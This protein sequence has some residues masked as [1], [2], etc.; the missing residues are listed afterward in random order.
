MM[1]AVEEFAISGE[2]RV[3]PHELFRG[4]PPHFAHLGWVGLHVACFGFGGPPVQEEA[5]V[6]AL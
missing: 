4:D 1:Y 2:G 3:Q 6:V 5:S